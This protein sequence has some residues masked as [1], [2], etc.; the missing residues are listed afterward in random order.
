MCRPRPGYRH[1]RYCTSQSSGRQAYSFQLLHAQL[2]PSCCPRNGLNRCLAPANNPKS[3][4]GDETYQPV[5]ALLRQ[6]AF[7]RPTCHSHQRCRPKASKH[8]VAARAC[9]SPGACCHPRPRPTDPI[10]RC[11]TSIAAIPTHRHPHT[12]PT[13]TADTPA[14]PS[15]PQAAQAARF[16][17]GAA[18]GRAKA[19][20][21][22]KA[23][24]GAAS[25]TAWEAATP[26]GATTHGPRHAA[27]ICRH[28]ASYR[29]CMCQRCTA[30][31]AHASKA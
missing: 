17:Q 9:A 18:A 25:L 24:L 30:I 26:I 15:S 7:D 19:T 28:A 22:A 11:C 21:A 14:A 3:C 31:R 16:V 8:R 29:A 23:G 13:S 20:Q 4:Q 10:D 27:A 2:L 5:C 6:T 1:D 12:T